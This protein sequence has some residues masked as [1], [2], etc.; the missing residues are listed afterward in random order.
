MDTKK[1]IPPVNPGTYTLPEDGET[2][3]KLLGG[4]CQVCHAFYYPIPKYCPN[5]VGEIGEKAVGDRG[6]VHSLTVI[7]AKPP[8]GLPQP[9]SVGYVDLDETGLRVFGL[10][11]PEQINEMKIG[12]HVCLSVRELGH[13]GRGAPRLRPVF[14][15]IAEAREV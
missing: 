1:E 10:F 14:T 2:A 8:L 12:D 15:L 6:R 7:R 13:D 4:F 3:P 11:D 5:C 9:Y